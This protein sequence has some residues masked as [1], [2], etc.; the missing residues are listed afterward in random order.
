MLLQLLRDNNGKDVDGVNWDILDTRVG[1]GSERRGGN[2]D[3][4]AAT[5]TGTGF[6]ALTGT[7]GSEVASGLSSNR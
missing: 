7:S 5:R 6:A 4:A 3:W 2:Y 1:S